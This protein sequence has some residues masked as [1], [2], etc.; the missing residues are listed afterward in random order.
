MT[1]KLIGVVIFI[2]S[3]IFVLILNSNIGSIPSI[4]KLLSP[5]HGFWSNIDIQ[6]NKGKQVEINAIHGKV[7]IIYDENHIPHIF[8]DNEEDLY[9]AQGYV[10]AQDRLWQMEF[11]TYVASG[12]LTELVG[13]K[14]L[15]LD[16]YH[17]RIGLKKSAEE[18]IALLT[19]DPLTKAP[20]TSFTQGVNAFIKKAKR[21]Y[22]PIEY[23]L[24]GYQPQEWQP[25]NS[26]LLLKYMANDLTGTDNDIEYT[27]ALKKFGREI[28][29]ILYPD[30]PASPDPII[31]IGTPFHFIPLQAPL[32]PANASL[33]P[34]EKVAMYKNPIKP[35]LPQRG[36]GSNNWVVSGSKTSS[37]MPILCND[38]HLSLS[39][40]SIWYEMQLNAPGINVYGVT[41]P[42]SPGIVI[43]YNEHIA[44]G[45]TNAGM[46]VRDWY[47]VETDASNEK[48]LI[49]NKWEIFEKINETYKVKGSKNHSETIKWTKIGPI[50]Y[51][52]QFDT[53]RNKLDLVMSW[54]ALKPSNDLKTFLLLNKAKNHQDYL[55]ALDEYWCP[56]QN[57][58]YADLENNIAIKEQGR[59][60]IRYPE[61]GKFIQNLKD[62]NVKNILNYFIPNQQNP[63]ILNPERG[64]ASSANQIPVDKNY[65]YYI[66]GFQYE[67]YRNRRINEVL[68]Q[69]KDITIDDMKNLQYDNLSIH[70]REALPIMLPFVKNT[71]NEQGKE[72][73]QK[74]TKWNYIT[75]YDS[76]APSYFYKWWAYF[77]TLAWDE[78]K[79]TDEADF[80]YPESYTS[81]NIMKNH[82]NFPLFDIE[83]T[84]KNETLQD[85][86]NISFDSTIAY[87]NRHPEQKEFRFFKNTSISH[88]AQIDAFSKKNI[89]IGGYAGI[90]NATSS[91]WGASVRLIIDFSNGKIQG[92]GMYPGGQSGNPGSNAYDTF[93]EAWTDGKYYRHHFYK[94]IHDAINNLKEEK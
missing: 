58:V 6:E 86:L 88:L 35:F 87:F 42:G 30:Y 94:N 8:A 25:I 90:V 69:S 93:V 28:F 10:M 24:L 52:S 19:N 38:P 29:D 5:S 50:V 83:G 64:F 92:Y 79:K 14:A 72:I 17:R 67:N 23:K 65:P 73:I 91:R 48:Y 59:F 49:G 21:G 44:W 55:K 31:P 85:V 11:I 62:A 27:N 32:K 77:E 20:I 51:D 75:N 3:V 41:L 9:Y 12:R 53:K 26:A 63:Y 36:L 22:L 40:P 89:K 46:D 80:I 61:Q 18:S 45:V 15:E 78:L 2:I 68:T 82:P 84:N 37:G 47:T 34:N 70:A 43:G 56:G 60:W 16:R 33:N 74:L 4:G 7:T 13:E 39:F 54:T 71:T 57:F 76:D 66:L 1:R 81:I